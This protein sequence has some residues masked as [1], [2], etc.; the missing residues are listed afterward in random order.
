MK[1]YF[2]PGA[3]SLAPRI[4][5]ENLGLKYEAE[6]VNL[7]DHSYAGGDFY[8]INPKGSVPVIELGNGEVLTENAVLM[9]YL[10]DQKP[11]SGMLPKFGTFERYR[12][13][14]WLNFIT[15]ELHKGFSPLFRAT[16]PEDYK[17]VIKE[18]LVKSFEFV[19]QTLNEQPFLMGDRVTAPDCYLFVMLRWADKLKVDLGQPI[20]TQY[21][22]RMGSLPATTRALQA[23]GLS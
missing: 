20:L 5:L 7:R 15:T 13:L 23:E 12:G 8:Q 3:C 10:C 16:T 2:S 19:A 18:K 14:E 22:E 9:Q 1:L 6:K 21:Y 17:G 4:L 11:D